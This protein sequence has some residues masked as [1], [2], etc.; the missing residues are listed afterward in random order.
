M[1]N[2]NVKAQEGEDL[3]P[4]CTGTA[5]IHTV[6]KRNFR[7]I[8]A[9]VKEY[10]SNEEEANKHLDN[11]VAYVETCM[12]FL[13]V[14]HHGEDEILFPLIKEDWVE[15]LSAEHKKL[16]GSIE[17]ANKALEF[18]H[19]KENVSENLKTLLKHIQDIESV[20][21]PHLDKEE[22]ILNPKKVNELFPGKKVTEITNKIS[23]H[24]KKGGKNP[25]LVLAL[26]YFSLSE[27]ELLYF[28]FPWIVTGFL[29]PVVWKKKWTPQAQFYWRPAVGI[30]RSPLHDKVNGTDSNV[31]A[32]SVDDNEKDTTTTTVTKMEDDNKNN[33]VVIS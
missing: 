33:D 12:D 3:G 2:S 20:L 16:L 9:Q 28:R 1:G 29:I 21:F 15:E 22:S 5:R 30:K 19:K 31:V 13:E 14:H 23:E 11:F 17:G 6:L 26:V 7:M 32:K 27:Q 18:L 10:E 24:G 25:P 8:E 4:L